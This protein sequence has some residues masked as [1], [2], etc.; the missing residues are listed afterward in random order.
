MIFAVLPALSARFKSYFL[1]LD[2]IR[3]ILS[4]GALLLPALAVYFWLGYPVGMED[5]VALAVGYTVI[6][7]IYL[8]ALAAVGIIWGRFRKKQIWESVAF[9]SGQFVMSGLAA[10]S[11]AGALTAFILNK[12][13]HE[14]FLSASGAALWI[15]L[16]F[17]I[18]IIAFSALQAARDWL[19]R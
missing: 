11:T 6:G 18:E 14:G 5:P 16:L 1:S 8:L 19:K 15:F 9:T 17:V 12:I 2:P 7:A 13:G 3:L 10:V 4:G